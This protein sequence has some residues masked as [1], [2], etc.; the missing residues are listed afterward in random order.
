MH[1]HQQIMKFYFGFI[2]DVL[3]FAS[4][5]QAL[6]RRFTRRWSAHSA[7]LPLPLCLPEAWRP[8]SEGRSWPQT[9]RHWLVSTWRS[10]TTLN[11]DTPSHARTACMYTPS[12]STAK[13]HK[14][15][16]RSNT[17]IYIWPDIPSHP[18]S[19]LSQHM[20]GTGAPLR[21]WSYECIDFSEIP[22]IIA[23]HDALQS[24][25]AVQAE[26]LAEEEAH[27]A[28]HAYSHNREQVMCRHTCI[29]KPIFL[30]C[31]AS[32]TAFDP[33][34]QHSQSTKVNCSYRTDSWSYL[35][36]LEFHDTPN[37]TSWFFAAC[38]CEGKRCPVNAS[39]PPLQVR[40]AG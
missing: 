1:P 34:R 28:W 8:S 25:L 27:V 26:T 33:A 9:G 16:I 32:F 15:Y 6:S 21:S 23:R 7:S 19:P 2:P 40:P 30:S 29:K 4:N 11:M 24:P 35:F 5:M 18:L 10:S 37:E 12:R 14:G 3:L 13:A 17:D 20:T 38:W 39:L 31:T 22:S 36:I